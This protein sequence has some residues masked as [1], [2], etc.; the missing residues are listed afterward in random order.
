MALYLI[1]L[2]IIMLL[3]ITLIYFSVSFNCEGI[4][5]NYSGKLK[6]TN[7]VLREK[8]ERKPV[9]REFRKD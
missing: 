4:I 9:S 2:G 3:D 5:V 7:K 8:W 6:E 1:S